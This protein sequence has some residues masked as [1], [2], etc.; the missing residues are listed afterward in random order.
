MSIYAIIPARGGSKGIKNKNLKKIGGRSLIEIAVSESM[1]S[2][3]VDEVIVST[4]CE[5]IAQEAI[6]F[7]AKI[8]FRPSNISGDTSSSES[9]I[10]H[11]LNNLGSLGLELP[12]L[13]VFVQATSPFNNSLYIDGTCMHLINN[14]AD[15][16]FSASMFYHFL[17]KMEGGTMTPINHTIEYRPRRQEINNCF[18]ENGAIYVFKSIDFLKNKMRFFGKIV[19]YE[20][21][22]LDSFEIDEPIDIRLANMIH[23]NKNI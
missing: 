3:Y 13:T 17:W 11:A 22:T 19:M 7:G 15:S 18:V 5:D 12:E 8:I 4:D 21:T 23:K 9:A 6:R 2:T 1:K 10:I 14:D 16:C 20:M